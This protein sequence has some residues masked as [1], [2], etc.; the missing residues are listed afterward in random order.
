ME[1]LDGLRMPGIP[2]VRTLFALSLVTVCCLLIISD[3]S[4]QEISSFE[5]ASA[6][7]STIRL[8]CLLVDSRPSQSGWICT[9]QDAKGVRMDGFFK[10]TPPPPGSIVELV[11]DLSSEGDFLFVDGIDVIRAPFDESINIADVLAAS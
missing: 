1:T 5:Q 6:A 3:F 8:E 7:G 9:F 10:S 4:A 2:T 11:A